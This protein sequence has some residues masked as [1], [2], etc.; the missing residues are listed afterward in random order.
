MVRLIDPSI[1]EAVAL[2][3]EDFFAV[4]RGGPGGTTRKVRASLLGAAIPDGSIPAEKVQIITASPGDVI[5][6]SGLEPP[7]GTVVAD[8]A[9]FLR[10][11]F[12][13]WWE[14]IKDKSRNLSGTQAAKQTG[15]YGPGDGSTTFTIPDYRGLFRRGHDGGRGTDPGRQFGSLQNSQNL[16]HS[17]TA[18]S[19][20]AGAH[21]HTG[22]VSSSGAHT[23]TGTAVSAGAHTHNVQGV[24]F[25]GGAYEGLLSGNGP[26][27]R[28]YSAKAYSAGAHT[29]TLTIN[30]SGAHTH[31]VT[32]ASNG[33][34]THAVTV[35]SDGGSEARPI[36]TTTLVCIRYA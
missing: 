27:N 34:H 1:A 13:A 6:T 11:D 12:P 23:H 20:S 14:W 4:D 28:T 10:S 15:Q 3:S 32:I 35:N 25:G 2:D 19:G 36:N 30:S 8:G 17:H 9:T 33:A 24:G 16:S 31:T 29:H 7:V 22:T 26:W 18:T 21:T 5:E